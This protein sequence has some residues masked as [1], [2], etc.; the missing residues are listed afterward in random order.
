MKFITCPNCGKG[1]SDQETVCPHC[2]SPVNPHQSTNTAPKEQ[3]NTPPVN[4][5]KKVKN[6]FLWMGC[7]GIFILILFVPIIIGLL[8]N[9]MI[10][11][12]MTDT[13]SNIKS[14]TT[15]STTFIPEELNEILHEKQFWLPFFI[16][17]V[18]NI[19]KIQIK[20]C[21]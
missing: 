3:T 1:I 2:D 7:L 12:S 20:F 10:E 19:L 14:N 15:I 13:S 9:S 4:T 16:K 18:Y 17:I 21:I 5:N 8:V 11:D 6:G